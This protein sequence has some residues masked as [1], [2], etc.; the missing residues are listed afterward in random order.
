M[1]EISRH[2]H[3]FYVKRGICQLI[4][5]EYDMSMPTFCNY[6]ATALLIKLLRCI[7]IYG[8]SIRAV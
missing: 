8:T 7:V 3:P 1:R 6:S 4:D 2:L 5:H